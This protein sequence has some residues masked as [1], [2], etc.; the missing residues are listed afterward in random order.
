MQPVIE[1][2]ES[3]V[4]TYLNGTTVGEMSDGRIISIHPS[5]T[6]NGAPSLEIYDPVI[7]TSIKICY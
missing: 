4:R 5:T 2:K 3:N 7:G 1:Y 6:L